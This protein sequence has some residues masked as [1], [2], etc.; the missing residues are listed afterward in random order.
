[1]PQHAD[2][3]L[4]RIQMKRQLNRWRFI[5]IALLTLLALAVLSDGGQLIPQRDYIARYSVTGII[6][7]D[8][9]RDDLL[10]E[11]AQDDSVKAVLIRI[12]SPGGT[13]SGGEQLYTSLRAIREHKPVVVVMRTLATSAAYMAA[14]GADHIVAQNG[15]LTGSIGVI[16]ET[17]EVTDLA[18]KIGIK[19]LTFKSAPLKASPSPFE[20]LTPAAQSAIMDVIT[21]FYNYFVDVVTD[22]RKLDR[23]DV[24]RIADGRIY[25]GRQALDLKLIDAI[26][27]ESDA[28]AWL[29]AEKKLSPEL[30]VRDV[31]VKPEK[32]WQELLEGLSKN[33]L[34]DRIF[35]LDGLAAIW[36]PKA[37]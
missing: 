23:K 12:D 33:S 28:L 20:K 13:A 30:D 2:I 4:D 1:M 31:K 32:D 24:I 10:D 14:M 36:Q 25:T 11:L 9:K 3:L 15:T 37:L 21:D 5:G 29:S 7:D 8:P 35:G 19:P 22:N 27:G 34:S 26:G 18:E 17:A 6:A 16:I